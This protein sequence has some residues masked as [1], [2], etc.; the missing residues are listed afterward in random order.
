M[1]VTNEDQNAKIFQLK[2]ASY[3]DYGSDFTNI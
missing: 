2:L 3:I 1:L